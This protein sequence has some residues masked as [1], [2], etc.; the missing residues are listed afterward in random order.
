MVYIDDSIMQKACVASAG[1]RILDNFR[2][3][4]DATILSR[5]GEK[6]ERVK[7]AEF[8]L[9]DPGTLPG[10][11]LLCSDIFGHVRQR[12]AEQ[13]LCCIRPTYGTV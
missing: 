13:G 4:F 11:P 6:T 1:S 3:P 5:L 7:L 2:S 10:S 12:A 9:S 8:G